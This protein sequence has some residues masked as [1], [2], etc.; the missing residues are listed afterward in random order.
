MASVHVKRGDTVAVITGDDKG[1]RGKCWKS[2][3]SW[4]ESSSTVFNIQ[5]A[6]QTHSDQSAGGIIEKPGPIHASNVALVCPSCK[7]P[8]RI[9]TSVRQT[10]RFSVC[11]KV[12]Q[13]NQL[14]TVFSCLRRGEFS[15]HE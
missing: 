15:W 1:K 10:A 3:P 13:S 8:T 9:G 11:A 6:H 2:F 14:G 12:R 5:E 7:G 4:A